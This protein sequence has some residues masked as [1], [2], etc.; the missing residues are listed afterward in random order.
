MQHD[1]Y[2]YMFSKTKCKEITMFGL[3]RDI[4]CVVNG[5]VTLGSCFKLPYFFLW[6][7][8]WWDYNLDQKFSWQKFVHNFGG[9]LL[10]GAKM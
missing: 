1:H 9:C 4:A 10:K 8:M 6:W 5:E 2:S 7:F 3:Q